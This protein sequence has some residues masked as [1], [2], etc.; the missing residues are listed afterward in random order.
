MNRLQKAVDFCIRH[1]TTLSY[2]IVSLLTAASEHIFSSVVFKCPCNSGNMLYGY[3]FLLAPAFILLLLGYVV[4]ARTWRLFT[5][6]CSPEKH[7]QCCSWRTWARFCQLLVLMTA[8]TSV[9]PLTWIAVS[10]LGANFYECAA[11]GS[12]MTASLFCKNNTNYSQ[13]QLFKLPCD[14]ELSEKMSSECLSFQAQSQLIGWFLIASIMTAALTSTCVSHCCSPVIYL[15]LKFWK[16]Y[17][18]KEHELFETKAKEHATKLAERNTNCFFEATDP[19][20]FHTPSNEDWQ[21]IS[22]LYTFNSQDQYYSMIHK[23]V[24]TNRGKSTK[25][26]EEGQDFAVLDFVDEAQAS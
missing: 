6:A 25:F 24:S 20:P 8:K 19:P 12:S 2:S 9:A 11:S 4:S 21:K 18:R 1:Q 26:K 3:S 15:Q 16:I 22:I 13:D 17:S 14:K 10:L 7:L 23:Y 5:G